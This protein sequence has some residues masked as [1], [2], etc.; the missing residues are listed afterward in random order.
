M[1]P[2]AIPR[3]IH[4][5]W[6]DALVPDAF[7]GYAESWRTHHPAWTYRL[8]TDADNRD[9]IARRYPSF[10]ATYDAYPAPIMRADAARY[11]ILHAFGGVYAD[12]DMECVRPL[13]D[14]IDDT[15]VVFAREP[16]A[17]EAGP[18]PV[19]RGLDLIVCN[20]LMASAPGHP[21]FEHV[22][23]LLTVFAHA[24]GPLDATGPFLL[25]RAYLSF[26]DTARI[27]LLS[28]DAVYPVTAA[29]SRAGALSSPAERA[30]VM[31]AALTIHHWAGTWWRDEHP[32]D[33]VLAR[34]PTRLLDRGRLVAVADVEPGSATVA[35]RA[36]SAPPLVS[37]LMVTRGRLELA[38]RAIH[39]FRA[40]TC[41]S[42]ELVIVDDGEDDALA[43]HVHAL[44]DARIHHVRV[45]PEH[46]T[47]GELRNVAVA[48]ATGEYVCQWDDDD[49]SDPD[50]ISLQVAVTRAL[51]A[52][53]CFLQREQIISVEDGVFARSGRR[54]WEGSFLCERARMP[55]YPAIPRGEDTHVA[56]AILRANRVVMLDRP[57]LYT[58][59][60]HGAN[61]FG[62]DHFQRL[63][64]AAT[65]RFEGVAYDVAA[66]RLARRLGLDRSV[67]GLPESTARARERGRERP[68]GAVSP[69]ARGDCAPVLILCPVKD[70]A[71]FLP[72]FME[73]LRSLTYAHELI[74][75]AF[76]E[77]D[78][79]D[80][81][82]AIIETELTALAREFRRAELFRHDFDFR[83]ELPRWDPG[84]QRRR[85]ATLARSRNYLLSR[86]LRDEE[87][88]LWM[89]VDVAA[90]P[91]DLLEQLLA[92][93]REIVVPHCVTSAGGPTFDLNT[94]RLDADAGERDWSPYLVDGILQPPRGAGRL[95]LESFRDSALIE[96]DAVGGSVLFIRADLHREGLIFP[97]APYRQH[98]ETEGLALLARDMGYACFALPRLEV[99]HPPFH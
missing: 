25:T 11:F 43:E 48:C 54:L 80:G 95:Y 20:A 59:V 26:A 12:L 99:I 87:W 19:E 14:L 76:L 6:R 67:I 61:T 66:K 10:L 75:I 97:V 89:D 79:R 56:V 38:S 17:H 32:V 39:C 7:A 16:A 31:G 94:F 42:V 77:S 83:S 40:Q 30:R 22:F 68:R 62:R 18:L 46:R 41:P 92:P 90:Y 5:T 96:V 88:V 78:S 49:L 4:Q 93:E 64:E 21:F 84:I 91:P 82:A 23:R 35:I 73:N 65:E 34:L 86:A 15:D 52:Q 13:D 27:R 69:P 63:L 33:S 55:S 36:D 1:T 74:S 24:P 85:R 37:A 2:S 29:E 70:A 71:R 81:T 53:A 72:R 50:R 47:L 57:D 51:G 60:F 3:L 28:A 98:I 8:W 9:L 45:P 58:Y 44:R